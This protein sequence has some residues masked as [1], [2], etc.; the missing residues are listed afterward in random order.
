LLERV[1]GLRLRAEVHVDGFGVDS[2]AGQLV[3]EECEFRGGAEEGRAGGAGAIG[4]VWGVCGDE[5]ADAVMKSVQA[6]QLSLRGRLTQRVFLRQPSKRDRAADP[7]G[8]N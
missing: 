5:G 8:T 3:G 7:R 4:L 2:W 6:S 1:F